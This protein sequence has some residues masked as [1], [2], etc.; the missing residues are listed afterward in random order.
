MLGT[1]FG[2]GVVLGCIIC[3]VRS[4]RLLSSVQT[5]GRISSA[6]TAE[7]MSLLM[8]VCVT[9]QQGGLL[10]L[11]R[12]SSKY[13]GSTLSIAAVAA[14]SIGSR[15]LCVLVISVLVCSTLLSCNRPTRLITMTL[16]PM[17]MFTSIRTLTVVTTEN[18]ALAS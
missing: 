15:W 14:T 13:S 16:P 8:T 12:A 4:C 2:V 1:V 11:T 9:G 17:I 7:N 18:A 10:L 6:M 5:I 3:C